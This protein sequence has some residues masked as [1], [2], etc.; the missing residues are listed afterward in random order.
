M[1]VS[2]SFTEIFAPD[3]FSFDKRLC[4][5][6]RFEI[7]SDPFPV[8]VVSGDFESVLSVSAFTNYSQRVRSLAFYSYGRKRRLHT[9]IV[10][11]LAISGN[12]GFSRIAN[13][14]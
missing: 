12:N 7:F 14:V 5:F 2:R 10:A 6:A 9:P 1:N 11:Y 8:D 3:L 13:I 4:G